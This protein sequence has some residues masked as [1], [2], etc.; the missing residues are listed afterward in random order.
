MKTNYFFSI[1]FLSL[2]IDC[3]NQDNK[4]NVV[5]YETFKSE[6]KLTNITEFSS[7][8]NA[9][10]IKLNSSKKFQITTLRKRN[11]YK[12]K[13]TSITNYYSINY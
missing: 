3:S 11:T 5:V 1:L 9:S 12:N 6:N 10:T 2:I 7:D 4:L 8:K 13:C